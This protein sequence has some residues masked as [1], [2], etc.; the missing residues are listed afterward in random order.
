MMDGKLIS[1]PIPK[2]KI[3]LPAIILPNLWP[4]PS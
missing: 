1:E 2:P 4:I 3:I